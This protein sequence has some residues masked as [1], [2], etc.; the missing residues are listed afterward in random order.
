MGL[1]REIG[2]SI[3][4]KEKLR[5]FR[6]GF[7]WCEW[8]GHGGEHQCYSIRHENCIT[9]INLAVFLEGATGRPLVLFD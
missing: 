3:M 5:Q 2:S 4:K 6:I 9:L 8:I 7:K 1:M